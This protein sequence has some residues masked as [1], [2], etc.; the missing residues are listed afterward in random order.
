MD[1]FWYIAK[2]LLYLS[3]S[4]AILLTI[5]PMFRFSGWWIRIGD[6]PRLQILFV[7][8]VNIVI[9]GAAFY[10]YDLAG[11]VFLSL[12]G[13]AC[14]YQIYW[15]FPYFP[16]YPNQVQRT[17]NANKSD[18]IRI[19]ISNVLMEN[20][21]TDELVRLVNDVKPDIVVLAE[22]DDFW[23]D[24]VSEIEKDFKYTVLKPL[25][26]EYGMALYSKL[27][28]IEPELMFIVEDDIPSIHTHVKLRSG[29]TIKLRCLHPRPPGPT[30]N[31]RSAERDAELLIVGKT[32]DETDE[33]TIVCGD[34]ND[35][36]WSRTTSQFQKISG[37]LDPR[38]GRGL[39]NS[40][41]AE[42]RL[43]RMPL[44][45]VFHSNDFRLVELKRMRYIGSDHFPLFI[46]LAFQA[47]AEAEQQ[48]PE[49]NNDDKQ[50]ADEKIR[51]GIES[52]NE[53]RHE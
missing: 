12:L 18:T 20:K 32:V 43:L 16:I 50:E 49:A 4:L 52:S 21:Q 17:H 2:I 7:C 33:P 51:E 28:L 25:D 26:N 30:Q 29:K 9:Y 27:E 36:A 19:L 35:V 41:H 47:D 5:L 8:L 37:L 10:P 34:L 48:E 14:V 11:W 39:F 53:K 38:I 15:I 6:F 13:A 23:V 3:G 42:H 45:H 40:F 22:V 46:E 24:S 44:D 1:T 31:E